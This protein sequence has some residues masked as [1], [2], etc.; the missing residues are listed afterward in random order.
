MASTSGRK[1]ANSRLLKS[2]RSARLVRA[3]AVRVN[4]RAAMHRVVTIVVVFLAILGVSWWQLA[5]VARRRCGR[6][7]PDALS[8]S[9]PRR[10]A[11]AKPDR[12]RA[13]IVW[14]GDSTIM[15]TDDAAPP[16][17]VL[18]DRR[19]TRPAGYSSQVVAAPGLDF[20]AYY[21]LVETSL[22]TRPRLIVMV[23]NLR[24]F[25]PAGFRVVQRH[26]GLRPDGRAAAADDASLRRTRHD[27]TQPR[28][29]AA[30]GNG[31]W[32]HRV[33]TRRGAPPA[34]GRRG[35]VGDPRAG[36]TGGAGMEHPTTAA[37]AASRRR[38]GSM[39]ARS[40]PAT[41]SFDLRELPSRWP[42]NRGR[43]PSSSSRRC[44]ST[45]SASSRSSTTGG[46]Q[47]A[48]PRCARR[49]RRP[50]GRS[51]I[52]T[53]PSRRTPSPTSRGISQRRHGA[54]VGSVP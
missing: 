3:C 21:A 5:L 2:M 47:A 40:D 14:L 49:S 45:C 17:P 23:A 10:A 24:L 27:R 39:R 35:M 54:H 50:A 1:S 48:S 37:R 6:G 15:S 41:P 31:A 9:A 29:G 52:S 36:A 51:S 16:Y 33:A 18:L 25:N 53:E 13:D 11:P 32:F 44:R 30:R 20:Y 42:R 4:S 38:C 19:A 8:V 34:C 46:S 26:R 43:A 28:A 7:R 12:A 22:A